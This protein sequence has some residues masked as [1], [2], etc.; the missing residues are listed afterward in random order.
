[1]DTKPLSVALVA[2]KKDGENII[3]RLAASNGHSYSLIFSPTCA[4]QSVHDFT[5]L[6]DTD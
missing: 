5:G 4:G 3:L 2:A 6:P 1:M